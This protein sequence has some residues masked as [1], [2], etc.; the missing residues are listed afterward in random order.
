MAEFKWDKIGALCVCLA[1]V[2]PLAP[3][4]PADASPAAIVQLDETPRCSDLLSRIVDITRCALIAQANGFA[5]S[6]SSHISTRPIADAV[7]AD[8]AA[9]R[10]C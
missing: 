3:T 9:R 1:L 6:S 2:L 5:Q 7:A 4:L 8:A 10:C